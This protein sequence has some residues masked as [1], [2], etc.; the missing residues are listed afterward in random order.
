METWEVQQGEA[1][2]D[3]VLADPEKFSDLERYLARTVRHLSEKVEDAA[4]DGL[5]ELEG[6]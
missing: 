6:A 2:A 3:R 1:H 4:M 5:P